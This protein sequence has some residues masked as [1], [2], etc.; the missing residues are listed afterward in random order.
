MLEKDLRLTADRDFK[1][2]FARGHGARG[3]HLAIKVLK[4]SLAAS[5]FGV[6]VSSKVAK[7]AVARNKLKRQ[8]RVIIYKHLT[9]VKTGFDVVVVARPSAVSEP[10]QALSEELEYLFARAKLVK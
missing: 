8:L 2:V 6:V 10:Y 3:K 7:K 4:N 1:K 5:R 9:Q